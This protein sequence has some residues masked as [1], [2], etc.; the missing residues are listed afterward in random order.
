MTCS[1]FNL[2]AVSALNRL[3]FSMLIFDGPSMPFA[4]VP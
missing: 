4:D 2:F 1:S 3:R